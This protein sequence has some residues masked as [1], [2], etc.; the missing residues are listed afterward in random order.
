MSVAFAEIGTKCCVEYHRVRAIRIV[1]MSDLSAQMDEEFME[2]WK[3]LVE[4]SP[5]PAIVEEMRRQAEKP[6]E[7]VGVASHE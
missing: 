1:N 2:C 3:K 5:A 4:V 7:P 6:S